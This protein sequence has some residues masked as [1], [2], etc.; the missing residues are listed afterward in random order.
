M[1]AQ[2]LR[3]CVG[4]TVPVSMM[5]VQVAPRAD[6]KRPRPEDMYVAEVP[7]PGRGLVGRH[8][9]LVKVAAAGINRPDVLQRMGAYPAPKGMPQHTYPEN[10][11]NVHHTYLEYKGND[12]IAY[13]NI[14][15]FPST[16]INVGHAVPK[17][18]PSL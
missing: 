12:A 17:L 7:T 16:H 13:A 6:G 1:A 18:C 3:R 4:A 15:V 9:L 5:A 2:L 11:G 14:F 10:K 8:E